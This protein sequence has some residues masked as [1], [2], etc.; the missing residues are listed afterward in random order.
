[1]PHSILHPKSL[2]YIAVLSGLS[3]NLQAEVPHSFSAGDPAVANHINDNFTDLDQRIIDLGVAVADQSNGINQD[4]PLN[5]DDDADAFLNAPINSHTTYI[6]TGMCNGPI[7][8]SDRSNVTIM[9]DASGSKDDGVILPASLL[10]DPF[11][12]IG[13][14]R[15]KAVTLENLTVDASNYVSKNYDFGN[16]VA[17]LSAGFQS[18]VTVTE[19]DFLG[20]D[21]ALDVFDLAMLRLKAGV[22]VTGFNRGGLNSDG[23]ANIRVDEPITVTG[24]VNTSTDD[25]IN[26]LNAGR[27]GTI[28]INNGG[29]FTAGTTTETIDSQGFTIYPAAV[30]AGDNGSILVQDGSSPTVFNGAVESGYSATIRMRGDTTI[31]GVLGAYHNS[32]MHL[33]DIVQD[34]GEIYAGDG[35]Y[36]RIESGT[37]TPVS[38]FNS[39]FDLYRN[40]RARINNSTLI[41]GGKNISVSSFSVLNLRGTTNLGTDGIDC[42]DSQNVSIRN[43]VVHGPI[44]CW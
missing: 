18:Y 1:M 44:S 42:G 16:N 7:W 24:I 12:A 29:T 15:A 30:W 39:A 34:G 21:W 26:A 2:F 27:N 38:T 31:H 43:S 3:A 9:G 14:W 37:L 13:A 32:V 20:G 11:A 6:L 28:K 8:I 22:S 33:T 35:G 4:V 23:G 19:V 5:C 25:Y 41:L 40:G 10:E 36:M 17:A